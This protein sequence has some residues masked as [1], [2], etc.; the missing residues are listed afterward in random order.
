VIPGDYT[1]RL[2]ALGETV[3]QRVHVRADPRVNVTPADFVTW[4]R[5]ARTI[6]AT[7][8]A[9]MRGAAQVRSLDRQ[10]A[11]LERNA[12]D[13]SLRTAAATVR[14]ELRPAVL[15]LVGNVS[16]PGHINLA[17]RIDWLRIQVGNNSGRPTAAQSETI[18]SYASQTATSVAQIDAVVGG[19]LARLNTQLRAA[20]LAEVH[21]AP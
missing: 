14:R 10:L 20:G 4:E 11:E 15:A 12:H 3:E 18:A 6:E 8:C 5:A 2:H 7:E 9:I 16:D 13:A 19:S 1:V 17:G 21:R